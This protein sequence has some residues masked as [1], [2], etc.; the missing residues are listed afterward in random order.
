MLE[1]NGQPVTDTLQ[2]QLFNGSALTAVH[3][4]TQRQ[5]L[6]PVLARN[7]NYKFEP[8]IIP[9]WLA[10]EVQSRHTNILR[11]MID[12]SCHG[13]GKGIYWVGFSP[14]ATGKAQ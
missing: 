1:A 8:E 7:E 2:S 13:L 3:C 14:W 9:P 4:E 6:I 12:P 5:L 10:V 11:V